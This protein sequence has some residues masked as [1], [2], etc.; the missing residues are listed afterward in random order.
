MGATVGQRKNPSSTLRSPFLSVTSVPIV[1]GILYEKPLA[2][3][4]SASRYVIKGMRHQ[5]GIY[6]VATTIS[7]HSFTIASGSLVRCTR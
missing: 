2:A 6:L 7:R 5:S 4:S 1:V 3:V